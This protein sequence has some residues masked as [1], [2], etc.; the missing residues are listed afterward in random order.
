MILPGSRDD[1]AK[2]TVA[3]ARVEV[4]AFRAPEPPGIE[5]NEVVTP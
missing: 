2:I 3:G 1:D 4:L 5:C